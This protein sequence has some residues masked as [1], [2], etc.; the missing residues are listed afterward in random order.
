VWVLTGEKVYPRAKLLQAAAIVYGGKRG[1]GIVIA[2]AFYVC[3]DD[4][5][6]RP[7]I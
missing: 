6:R 7:R 4:L 3:G 5:S 2:L 1:R